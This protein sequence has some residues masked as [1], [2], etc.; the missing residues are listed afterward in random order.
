MNRNIV[1]TLIA[2]SAFGLGGIASADPIASSE[3]DLQSAYQ[4]ELAADAAARTSLL[5]AGQNR[6]GFQVASQDGVGT[7]NVGA[8]VQF[9]YTA[10]FRDDQA[11]DIAPGFSSP[12]GDNDFASGFN[13][14]RAR[15]DFWGNI[16]SPQWTYRISMDA[17]EFPA[18]ANHGDFGVT[19]AYMQY[20]LEGEMEG[21]YVR[22]G[23][24]KL[25]LLAEENIAPEFGLAAERSLTN[26]FFSQQYSEGALFGYHA[27]A[28]NFAF[29]F[30]DGINSR[31]TQYNAAGESDIALTA[32]AEVKFAGDWAQFEDLTSWQGSEYASKVGAAVHWETYGE[33]G[34]TAK[35]NAASNGLGGNGDGDIFIWTV[36]AQ[37]E[38]NGWNMFAAFIG[39]HEEVDGVTSGNDDVAH[40][41]LV[42]QGGVFVTSQVELFARYDGLYIDDEVFASGRDDNFHFLTVGTNYYVV[43]NSHALKLTLDLIFAFEETDELLQLSGPGTGGSALLG[44]S[45]ASSITGLLGQSDDTEI[46]VRGQAQMLF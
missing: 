11:S 10:S 23:I 24:L 18:P 40:F 6:S 2:G 36:D 25:P 16:V 19:W 8:L 29:A 27:D 7:L 13:V 37:V 38:G 41:G 42:V 21:A 35:S 31:G 22:A 12:I 9:R 5:A 34:V 4:A 46:V 14:Q 20:D 30:S 17:S 44:G 1:T 26:E 39:G 45:S 28:W 33:T 3:I 32:R 15:L 43:E